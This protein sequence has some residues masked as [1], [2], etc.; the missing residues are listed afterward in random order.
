[1]QFRNYAVLTKGLDKTYRLNARSNREAIARF[2]LILVIFFSAIAAHAA[3]WYVRPDGGTRYSASLPTGQCNGKADAP[4]PGTGV[5]QPCAFND[6]RFLWATGKYTVS[7]GPD[8]SWVGAGGDTYIIDCPTECRIGYNGPNAADHY[9]AVVGL[10]GSSG[11]PAPPSGTALAHTRVLGKNW[12]NCKDPSAKAHLFGGYGV[13]TVF[14]AKGNSYVDYACFEITDHSACGRATLNTPCHTSYPLDDYANAGI[15]TSNKTTNTTFTDIN[16]HGMAAEGMLGPTG[17]GVVLTRVNIVGN[18]LSGWNMDSGDGTTGTGTLTLNNVGIL[19]N[20]CS[21]MYPIPDPTATGI[22]LPYHECSDDNSGGY[23]DGIGTATVTSNPAWIVNVNHSLAA[24]NTQ[25]GFDLL[26]LQGNGSR[27]TI[28]DSMAYSNM[29][30]QLKVG[31]ASVTRNN[32]IVGNCNALREPIPGTPAGYNSHLSDFCRAADTMIALAVHDST[33]TYFQNNTMY[34]ANSTGV[35]IDCGNCTSLATINYENNVFVGFKNNVDDG[36]PRGGTGTFAN[37]IYNS[38]KGLF[39]NPG[40]VFSNNATFHPKTNWACP[41]TSF[42]ET[43]AICEDPLLTDETWHLYGYGEMSPTANSPLIRNGMEIAGLTTDFAG[44]ARPNAPTIGALEL[45][46]DPPS[47]QPD[48]KPQPQTTNPAPPP[49]T[50]DPKPQ[51]Q[52]TN[53]KPPPGPN[54]L[55]QV[56]AVEVSPNPATA[57]EALLLTTTVKS[58]SAPGVSPG[59]LVMFLDGHKILGVAV[60]NNVGEAELNVPGLSAG[61]HS[62]NAIY[63][64]DGQNAPW[65]TGLTPLQVNPAKTPSK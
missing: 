37:P 42:D 21:E 58:K 9:L 34:S 19:W 25:D 48:P 18:P 29:G 61:S 49:Q 1:M 15:V 11:A 56:L 16:I 38:V 14:L 12:A 28:T 8:W 27:L 4:Y 13:G 22:T 35:E 36:Y 53:P 41:K 23:G 40:S 7:A 17:D 26:H 46:S 6:V 44:V 59:G 65:G 39:T 57:N 60:L 3:T 43:N 62:I 51:P 31:A 32:L 63:S 5:N 54:P 52:T 64:G 2:A 24:Y 10:P 20:G 55:P 45:G 47:A 50:T 33:P 30:Q